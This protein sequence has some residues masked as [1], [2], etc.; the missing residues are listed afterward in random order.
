MTTAVQLLLEVRQKTTGLDAGV[1]AV[2]RASKQM[3]RSASSATSAIDR[4]SSSVGKYFLG[5]VGISAVATALNSVNQSTIAF[6]RAMA[7]LSA[8][9]GAT[10]KDLEY[11]RISAQDLGSTTLSS[12]TEVA[13]AFKLVGSVKADLLDNVTALKAVTEEVIKLSEASGIDLVTAANV[14]GGA[15]N[16][17]GLEASEAA[18][19]VNVLAAGSKYGAAE[20]N[21]I[22]E[23]LKFVGPVAGTLGISLEETVAAIELLAQAGIKG[24]EAG[25]GLRAVLIQLSTQS[26]SQL[27]PSVVGLTKALENLKAANLDVGEATELFGRTAVTS[28][29]ALTNFSGQMQQMTKD[30]TNTNTAMEQAAII[31]DSYAGRVKKL[32]NAWEGLKIAIGE[33]GESKKTID[34]LTDSVQNLSRGIKEKGLIG[35]ILI[36]PKSQQRDSKAPPTAADITRMQFGLDNGSSQEEILKSSIKSISEDFKRLENEASA[37]IS[38]SFIAPIVSAGTQITVFKESVQ[39][40]A[41]RLDNAFSSAFSDPAKKNANNL[42]Q[43]AGER[44]AKPY[45]AAAKNIQDSQ[46]MKDIQEAAELTRQIKGARPN[47]KAALE[48]K[49]DLLQEKL[50][51]EAYSKNG[52]GQVG[53]AAGNG[54]FSV[55][56]PNGN[57][58]KESEIRR[59]IVDDLNKYISQQLDKKQQVEVTITVNAPDKAQWVEW[60]EKQN[61]ETTKKILANSAKSIGN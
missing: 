4:L 52:M 15:L 32:S 49:L 23:A 28:G 26:N 22:G 31:T 39:E 3:V 11:L 2:D 21:D 50:N 29:L 33:A 34:G 43:L 44:S 40:A 8:I 12:A 51:K 1:V 41:T 57:S 61:K 6:S 10:G 46:F 48:N 14:T 56:G 16:Q 7:D 38:K 30:V 24:S 54:T 53:V 27:N 9:T 18:R 58:D 13:T 35:G 19:V 25:T 55:V 45:D 47:E 42:I 36:G 59:A 5:F 60:V 37:K 17:F 20:V